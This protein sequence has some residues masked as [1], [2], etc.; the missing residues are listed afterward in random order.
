M[1]LDLVVVLVFLI[2][3]IADVLDILS[4]RC[5]DSWSSLSWYVTAVL[6]IAVIF[7][8]A[9][10]TLQLLS[11]VEGDWRARAWSFFDAC[12]RPCGEVATPSFSGFPLV[13]ASFERR[14]F[15]IRF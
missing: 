11:T 14:S 6:L 12:W 5:C 4:G 10:A 2:K 7:F 3:T 15:L 9:V 13:F 1:I 8:G